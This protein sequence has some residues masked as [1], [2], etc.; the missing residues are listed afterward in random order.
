MGRLTQII[1]QKIDKD[2][3]GD[4]LVKESGNRKR[5]RGQHEGEGDNAEKKTV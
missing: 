1:P 5:K 2:P 4:L 3:V